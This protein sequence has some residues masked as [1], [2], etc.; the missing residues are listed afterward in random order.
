M[1]TS[2]QKIS[3]K[4]RHGAPLSPPAAARQGVELPFL[5]PAAARQ[6]V[7][8]PFLSPASATQGVEHPFSPQD[9]STSS[10]FRALRFCQL[11]GVV[12]GLVPPSNIEGWWELSVHGTHATPLKAWAAAHFWRRTSLKPTREAHNGI[13]RIPYSLFRRRSRLGLGTVTAESE[14]Q[15]FTYPDPQ[16]VTTTPA[17]HAHSRPA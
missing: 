10:G 8:H 14:R 17:V 4:A 2:G 16:R 13:P 11:V 7:E 1:E 9:S 3:R 6:G 5:A 15:G 12:L